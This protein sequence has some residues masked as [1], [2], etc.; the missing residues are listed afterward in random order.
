MTSR[1]PATHQQ[2]GR[3]RDVLDVAARNPVCLRSPSRGAST[4]PGLRRAW[5][6]LRLS[7]SSVVWLAAC[8]MLGTMCFGWSAWCS[9]APDR[10]TARA[11][12]A[13]T[14]VT[15]V[16]TNIEDVRKGETVVA[17]DPVTGELGW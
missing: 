7:R 1:R 13:S 4:R 14:R 15:Y 17:W 2:R 8:L 5:H 16:T 3:H 12:T 9:S 6:T 11:N 10:P